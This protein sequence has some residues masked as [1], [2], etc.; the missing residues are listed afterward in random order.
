MHA[1]VSLIDKYKWTAVVLVGKGFGEISNRYINYENVLQAKEWLQKQH[2]E[3]AQFSLK[4]H[5]V[6]K[7]KKFW[8]D[9]VDLPSF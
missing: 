4:V 1:L 8:N 9:V 7:W 6:C 3:N 5:A 2:P